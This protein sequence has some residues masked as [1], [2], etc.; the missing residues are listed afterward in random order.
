MCLEPIPASSFLE[1]CSGDV[2]CLVFVSVKIDDICIL[3]IIE[4][5]QTGFW[6]VFSRSVSVTAQGGGF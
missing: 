2:S 6:F 4:L 5:E 1:C 3:K